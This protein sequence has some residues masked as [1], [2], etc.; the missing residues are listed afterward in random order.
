MNQIDLALEQLDGE[1]IKNENDLSFKMSMP[2]MEKGLTNLRMNP[3]NDIC[4]LCFFVVVEEKSDTPE[5][6][7]SI[8]KGRREIL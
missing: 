4:A 8:P 5:N 3:K 6:T 2:T 7:P 1:S